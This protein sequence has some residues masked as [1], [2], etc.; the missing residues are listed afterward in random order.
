MSYTKLDPI[1]YILYVLSVAFYR[2]LFMEADQT[3]NQTYYFK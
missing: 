3:K 1:T 2:N